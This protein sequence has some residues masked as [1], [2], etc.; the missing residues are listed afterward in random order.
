MKTWSVGVIKQISV[1]LLAVTCTSLMLSGCNTNESKTVQVDT[2]ATTLPAQQNR[3]IPPQQKQ[4]LFIGQDSDTISEYISNTPEDNIEAVTLYSQLKSNSKDTTLFG[5]YSK[6]NWNSGDMDFSKTLTESPK[7]AL[8]IGL[9]IDQCNQAPHAKNIAAGNYD[10]A[11]NA[12]IEYLSALSP[13]RVFLRIGYEFDGPWNCYQ[14]ES[15]IAAY[16]KIVNAIRAAGLT[17]VTNVWQ[18]ATWPDGYGNEIYNTGNPEHF[19]RWYPGDDI[20]DWVGVSVFYRDLTNW[21]YTPPNTP[22][23]G[24]QAALD[25]AR[26]H[27][28]P[29]MIAESAP[30]GYR[31]EGLTQSPIQEN[32]PSPVTAE[33]IW[34]SW[35]VPFFDFIE[36][37]KDVIGAVAYINANWESQNMWHCLPAIQAG[38]PGCNQGNWGDSRVHINS[39]IKAKWL[40]QINDDSRWIQ[41]SQY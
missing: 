14:P 3:F 8:A 29:V 11:L 35:Y 6:A 27:N 39:Y 18:S 30:Q 31:I 24:Q 40:E 38:K 12:L 17:N 32:K 28:K 4:L 34:Q 10:N 5:I 26:T 22:Q 9:A 16:R 15:Y 1:N 20:V 25:F 23:G 21:N 19:E 37:N 33:H 36:T 41:T 13:K 2:P 7:A